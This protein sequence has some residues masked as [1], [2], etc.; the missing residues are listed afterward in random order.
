MLKLGDCVSDFCLPN[1][2]G[3]EIC[4]RDISGRWIVLYFYPKDSTPGCTTQACDFNLNLSDF[5]NANAIVLGISPDSQ[6]KHTKFIDK[7]SLNFTLLSDEDK[8]LCKLF[9][10][11]ELKKFMGKEYMG[12]VRS[13]FIISPENQ[14]VFEQRGVKVKN[15]VNE[16]LERLLNLQADEK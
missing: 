6:A 7:N 11:W 15:H 3:E 13:T 4:F 10:V 1:Q 8:E 5:S 16:V 2:D 9:G 14:I 12:V